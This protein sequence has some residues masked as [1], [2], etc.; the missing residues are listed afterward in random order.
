MLKKILIIVFFIATI[1]S[2]S[3]TTDLMSGLTASDLGGWWTLTP[4]PTTLG[5]AT[6]GNNNTN[7]QSN[8]AGSQYFINT[9]S[10][11]ATGKL[12]W[13][14]GSVKYM[15][16]FFIQ[17]IGGGYGTHVL[18]ISQD[19]TTWTQLWTAD[20]GASTVQGSGSAIYKVRYAQVELRDWCA[21]A[22]NTIKVS[23]VII[24]GR[25]T[26][27]IPSVP[28]LNTHANYHNTGSTTVSWQA[29]T[30]ADT[31]GET[32][33]YD[34][35]VGTSSGASDILSQTG[36]SGTTS[37][38]FT[39]TPQATYYWS[40]RSFDGYDYSSWATESS[41]TFTD[42]APT[43][44]SPSA[45]A[46]YHNS[47]STT[48]NWTASTDADSDAITY[49]YNIGTSSG[50]TQIANDATT[51]ATGSATFTMTPT[52]NYYWKVKACDPY[53]CSAY[54]TEQSFTFTNSAPVMQS[55]T[56]APTT[57]YTTNTLTATASATDADGDSIT[58]AYQWYKDGSPI[59]GQTSSTLAPPLVAGSQ[60]KVLVTP[61]DPYTSGTGTYS[62]IVT[63]LGLPVPPAPASIASTTG[64]FWV[65]TTW[66]PGV[67]NI[68]DSYNV[69]VNGV[70]T[71]GTTNTFYNSTLSAHASQNVIV[72]AYNSTAG[73]SLSASAATKNTQ[74]PDNPVTISNISSSYSIIVSQSIAIY[75]TTTDADGDTITFSSNNTKGTFNS[76]TGTLLWT[77]VSGDAG[78]YV[79]NITANDGYGSTSTQT[80][81][82][83]VGS[84]TP[85]QP[86]SLT[87]STS[88]FWVNYTWAAGA[89]TD[90]FNV[91]YNNTWTNGS[92][93]ISI[94]RQVPPH[95]WGNITVYGYNASSGALG[96]SASANT[97]IP[98]NQ[99]SVSNVAS[100]YSLV[101]G[102]TLS[103]NVQCSDLDGDTCTFT[104]SFSK[105]TFDSNTGILTWNTGLGDAGTYSW[106]FTANDGYINSAPYT[107]T[108]NVGGSTPL[109]PVLFSDTTGNFWVNYTWQPGSNTDTFN[110]SQNSTWTNG[111]IVTFKNNTVGAH[112]WSNIT[113][114]GY[115]STVNVLGSCV[116]QNTQVPNNPVVLS[117]IS[118]TYTLGVGQLLAIYPTAS[119]L[120]NDPL[121]FATNANKGTFYSN[122]GT[123][124]WTPQ[125]GENGT[126]DWY[127][128]VTDGN[129]STVTKSFG[130]SVDSNTPGK[131]LNLTTTTGNFWVNATWN[132]SVNTDSFNISMNSMWTNGTTYDFMNTTLTPHAWHNM[133]VYGYNA[134]SGTL[135][136][137]AVVSVQIPN[138]NP[139]F[140]T[141]TL[142]ASSI[143][144]T[145]ST[146]ISV[147]VTDADNDTLTVKAGI[148]LVG[149]G[150][151]IN[152]TMTNTPNSSTYTYDFSSLTAGAYSVVFYADDG[153]HPVVSSQSLTITVTTAPSNGGGNNNGGGGGGGGGGASV[154]P[155]PAG[156]LS[157]LLPPINFVNVTDTR[158]AADLEKIG[159]CLSQDFMLSSACS[160]GTINIVKDPMNY[161][162]L[163]GAYLFSFIMIFIAA[164]IDDKPRAYFTDTLLY[165]TFAVIFVML[166]TL[167]GL[168]MFVLNFVF[169]SSLPGYMF[170]SFGV[171]AAF[172]TIA[173]DQF[174]YE[175]GKKTNT[176]T[177]KVG[178][179]AG[180]VGESIENNYAVKQ[181]DKIVK[182]K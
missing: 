84:S 39:M 80:F 22:G 140:G 100:S 132:K 59:G 63:V 88:N 114:C 6:D 137:G 97:Q 77:P 57:A 34:V 41:F 131:P 113:V 98:N 173:G 127:I 107:F 121:T 129:G 32:I 92:S 167:V 76:N 175:G 78:A 18:L 69:S 101:E 108:V 82:V 157:D 99:P 21:G 90:S 160:G 5:Y 83:T 134:T 35:R 8:N 112:G 9:Q 152:H 135:G 164:I 51:T 26:N 42:T 28:V 45:H 23:T 109:Q 53:A 103:I 19:A 179:L 104:R 30:D 126:Y 55:N 40:V 159:K 94:K 91:S 15:K 37:N 16:S 182:G 158:S 146:T 72:Y 136:A 60:Y 11:G 145:G 36:V 148:T 13:D 155:T 105:G 147:P 87:A 116:A 171:W 93:A 150:I 181:W 46:N 10:C 61:S 86:T 165:G 12:R 133:T 89:N 177:Q 54:T 3:A 138:N 85:G 172:I 2:A 25:A 14:M 120:D 117:N 44:P 115:N 52:N 176:F 178:E 174:T 48:V 161:W 106:S 168:N 139:V 125:V 162:V 170:G 71:N 20:P 31:D 149:G 95:G 163:V 68:T 70:W 1:H 151:E 65:N 38:S 142:S 43:V 153:Y 122:N 141:G 17:T 102:Q 156:N 29:S 64:N 79:W 119:D 169:Q 130:V 7:I 96:L 56:I 110:I 73:G 62:N 154:Q 50:G 66:S 128:N 124:R 166:F 4:D 47:A 27:A 111:T 74:I 33:T 144:T 24:N 143:Y 123:L 67:G 180:N 81:T 118:D 58:Y 75:P 49:H